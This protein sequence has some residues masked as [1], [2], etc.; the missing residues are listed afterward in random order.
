MLGAGGTVN[1]VWDDLTL[2]HKL[3]VQ[4][5]GNYFS[6]WILDIHFGVN[7]ILLVFDYHLFGRVLANIFFNFSGKDMDDRIMCPV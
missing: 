7:L 5:D 2:P 6:F 3:A 1:Y 4:L